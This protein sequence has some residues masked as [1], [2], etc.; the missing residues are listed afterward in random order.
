M[1][2]TI[3]ELHDEPLLA[4]ILRHETD[5]GAIAPTATTAA[6]ARPPDRHASPRRTRVDAEDR[7]RDLA[8][9]G[10]D[11][12]RQRDDLA[13]AHVE[14]DVEEHALARQPFDV[15]HRVADGLRRRAS[16]SGRSRPTIARMRSSAVRPA[17]SRDSTRRAVAEHGHA[18][19]EREDL[20]EPVRD[21]EDG[22]ARLAQRRRRRRTGARPRPPRAPRSARP[23][24]S[25]AR[26]ARAPWRSRRSAA[27]RSRA[28]A[29]CDPGSSG[30]PR[31]S[32][33]AS[34]AVLIA[35]AVD[36]PARPE[37]LPPDEDVLD[38]GEVGEQRRLLV[39][40]R[41]ARRRR[42]R[43]G[44]LSATSTPLTSSRAAVRRVHAGEDLDERRLAG[45]VLAD[46]GV[47]LAGEEVD[48]DVLDRVDRPEGLRR[49]LQR[50]DRVDPRWLHHRCRAQLP[51]SI[52]RS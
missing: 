35:R 6:G 52:T 21:E 16:R 9:P 18:L 24:R 26:R 43:R 41:D 10:A 29:R 13:G 31:R 30:T 38:D 2:R 48:R 42:P 37:R 47:R 28:R 32:K 40:D 33:I 50:Q 34:P 8:A 17:S 4:A 12:A 51:R 23:S 14:A 1:F 45:P 46:Q 19:A 44:P 49:M 7:A 20:L 5:T 39:D 11:Q 25:P 3:D 36:A 22:D 15:E 27:R